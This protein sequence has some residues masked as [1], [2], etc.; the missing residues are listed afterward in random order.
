M[1]KELSNFFQKHSIEYYAVLDYTQAREINPAIIERERFT[2][3]SVILFLLPYY[4]GR[5]ENLS[6]YAAARDYHIAIREVTSAL[7]HALHELYPTASA[8]GY[9]DHSPID[10]RDAALK[11]GLGILGDSGLLINEKYGTYIFVADVVTD[12]S[13]SELGCIGSAKEYGRCISCGACGRA[14]PTGLLRGESPDCLSAITQRK[15]ELADFEV[16]LMRKFNTVWGCDLCQS[17]CPYNKDPKIT[18]IKF[19]L[20]D[21][22]TVLTSDRLAEMSKAEFNERAFA[23]RG[24]KTVERNLKHLG[25]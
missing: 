19:F 24:R 18:P 10:E 3:R 11:A 2:P 21:R 8:K 25:Y 4:A 5:T 22:I 17:A 12:I 20:E 16:D 1:R 6:V 7:I 14:C 9:G 13:P 23:W 15:G